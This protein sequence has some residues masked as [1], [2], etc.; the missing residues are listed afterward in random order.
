MQDYRLDRLLP[1]ATELQV[2]DDREVVR[3]TI[4]SLA[5]MR[6]G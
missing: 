3:M 1:L 5:A 4:R 6:T 2:V